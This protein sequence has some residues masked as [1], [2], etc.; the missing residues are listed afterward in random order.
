LK[1][2]AKESGHDRPWGRFSD[3]GHCL[4]LDARYIGMML[5]KDQRI[6]GRDPPRL[7]FLLRQPVC[8]KIIARIGFAG[9][10]QYSSP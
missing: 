3:S 4:C 10:R 7:L 8:C 1:K 5:G 6:I 9:S 2:C